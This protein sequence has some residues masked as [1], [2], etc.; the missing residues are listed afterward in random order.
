[1]GERVLIVNADDLGR[2]GMVNAGIA[3]AHED[4]I[5]TSA[6]LMVR[7]P[8]AGEA[9]EYA[10]AHPDLA[11][12]LHMDLGEWVFDGDE[13]RAA[14]EVVPYD[15]GEAV[16]RELR[17]QLD[18]FRDL[19]GVDPTH[20]DSHQHVHRQEPVAER[21]RELAA[22]LGVPLRGEGPIAFCGDFYGRT[23]H[24]E[25]FHEGVTPEA[26]TTIIT[27]LPPG[28][29]ELGC[30]PGDGAASDPAYDHERRLEVEALCDERVRAAIQGAGVTLLSFRDV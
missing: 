2:C 16:A 7:W 22:E 12:G 11:V 25:P 6:S 29:T 23:H 28:V 13:W 10:A 5:V 18:T 14:Y 8:A 4:G 21:A 15:D 24:G 3:R 27:G 1:M 19:L 26:L 20:L 9:A 17:A 30:H